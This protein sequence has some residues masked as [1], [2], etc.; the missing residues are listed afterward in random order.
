MNE[1]YHVLEQQ[2]DIIGLRFRSFSGDEDF[3]HMFTIIETTNKADGT[4]D[5]TTLKEI[6]YDYQHLTNCDP[7]QD[8]LFAEVDEEV[9]AYARVEWQQEDVSKDRIYK[10][11]L[12]ITPKWRGKGIENTMIQWCENR[13]FEISENHDNFGNKFFELGSND[14]KASYNKLVESLGYTVVRYFIEM[15]RPLSDIPSAELRK[16][17]EVR[18]VK[19]EDVRK[20][21]DASVEAFR[22]H[23]GTYVLNEEDYKSWVGSKY[24]QPELWQVAWD[25]G[26]VVASVMNYID[27]D[28]NHQTGRLVG[29]TEEISTRKG[30]RR[31]GIAAALI[32]RSMHIHRACGMSEVA[33]SVDTVNPNGALK[34]YEYLGYKKD[35]TFYN[36]RKSF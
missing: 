6:I 16:G 19:P 23:W 24:F 12:N 7:Y 22:D 21:W 31:R 3:P 32:V 34:L 36:Y 8:M 11:L 1:K 14:R 9:V 18:P 33:L 28:F 17:I 27:H 10:L 2:P 30:W 25:G 35:K 15:S 29:W 20:I 26:E 4:Q 5:G 13:L